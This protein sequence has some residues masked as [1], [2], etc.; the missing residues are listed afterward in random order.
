MATGTPRPDAPTSPALLPGLRWRRVFPGEERQLAALRRWLS[1]LLPDCP[2]RDDVLSV[3]TELGGNAICHTASG[4]GGWFAVEIAWH[5]RVVRVAVA[6]CGAAA[7][8][9]VV[10]DPAGEH[11]RGLLVVRGLAARTGQCG[12]E[13]G[14]LVWADVPWGDAGAPGPASPGDGYEAVIREGQASLASRF[15][16]VPSWFGWSTL[17]W[18]ALAGGELVAAP[19]AQELA[20]LLARAPGRLPPWPPAARDPAGE[21]AET[22]R[23]AGREQRPGIPAQQFPLGH[24]PLPRDRREGTHPGGHGGPRALTGGCRPGATA[25]RTVVPGGMSLP[26]A[27]GSGPGAARAAARTGDAGYVAG[28]DAAGPGARR[29]ARRAGRPGPGRGRHDRHPA[30]GHAHDDRGPSRGVPLRLAVL[31]RRTA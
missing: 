8:P 6:D 16:G 26:D 10:D 2:A 25:G 20:S 21:D 31:A 29:A 1:S 24:A 19:S 9:R 14:R 13:R 11:G 28:A 3:A 30:A 5:Q 18:W 22:A 7:G 17:Q 27:A 15:A 4:R 23:A 12:D